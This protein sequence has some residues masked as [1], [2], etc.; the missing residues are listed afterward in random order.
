VAAATILTGATVA[1]GMAATGH[2]ATAAALGPAARVA[3]ASH[4]RGAGRVP[5]AGSAGRP[6]AR[7]GRGHQPQPVN[8]PSHGPDHGSRPGPA[9]AAG[10]APQRG[11]APRPAGAGS[12]SAGHPGRPGAALPALASGHRAGPGRVAPAGRPGAIRRHPAARP[13]RPYLIYDSV[14]PGAIPGHHVIATYATGGYAVSP[15]QVAGRN[16]LWIDTTGTDY[17]A[18]ILDVEP[19]DATPA[20]AAV[21]A[22]QRLSAYPHALA[23]IY[24]MLSQW[25][26]VKAS[27]ATL[28]AWM[29]ARVRYWIADPTGVPH[30]VPGSAA[31]QWYWGSNYDISTATPRF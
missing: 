3:A 26:A 15:S 23:R 4:G 17:H 14:T 30:V 28:P 27:I 24:T 5:A 13:R 18:S 6:P 10:R 2:T 7:R 12:R 16:V 31:T 25:P 29:R 20:Q 21:W 22:R 11:Q 9:G 1:T 19:G 8:A